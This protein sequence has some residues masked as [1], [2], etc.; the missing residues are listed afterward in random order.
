ML[1]GAIFFTS[2]NSITHLCFMLTTKSN[3]I[4]PDCP[5]A[6]ICRMATKLTNYWLEGS[7]ST[8]IPP[9]SASD[10]VGQNNKIGGITFG[11]PFI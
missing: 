9:A 7:T 6:A 4:L 1:V 2:I 3:D 5:S 11:A 8:A 10:V